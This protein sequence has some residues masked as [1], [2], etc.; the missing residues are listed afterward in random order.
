VTTRP[1]SVFR[2]IA[3]LWGATAVLAVPLGAAPG[4]QVSGLRNVLAAENGGQV[5]RFA[6]QADATQWAAAN[7]IDGKHW[8]PNQPQVANQ[9]R[10]WSSRKN[11]FPQELTFGFANGESRTINKIVIDP[12]TADPFFL[13]RGVKD[14]E[15]S[16]SGT[17]LDGVY[18]RV[19]GFRV[20]NIPEAQEFYLLPTTAKFLRVS[21]TSNWGSN[22]FV[23]LGEV[24][25]YEP[26]TPE[27]GDLEE[28]IVRQE[29]SLD[30]LKRYRRA[31]EALK[32]E[33]A[34]TDEEYNL[35]AAVNG[36]GIQ[37][38]TSQYDDS[39]W[40]AR[41][42]IDGLHVVD[43]NQPKDRPRGWSSSKPPSKSAPQEVVFHFANQQARLID[44][45]RLDPR[46]TDPPLIGRHVK[47]FSV[48]VMGPEANAKWERVGSY[49]LFVDTRQTQP[50]FEQ[51][52]RFDPVEAK[53]VKLQV[54]ANYGSDSCCELGEFEVFAARITGTDLDGVIGQLE[55]QLRDLK[56][57]REKQHAPTVAR[58]DLSY[59]LSLLYGLQDLR[60]ALAASLRD[61]GGCPAELA[62]LARPKD[63]PPAK[64]IGVGGQEVTSDPAKWRGPYLAG[65][66][67]VNPFTGTSDASAWAYD[68]RAGE[69]RAANDGTSSRG[70]PYGK[71]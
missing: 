14:V 54:T 53:L 29:Q 60:R 65:G 18:H 21:L 31:L 43:P 25:A 24:E 30:E 61:T 59:E 63:Q 15:V 46:T 66:V 41:N 50:P 49:E 38:S 39:L 55:Q 2:L 52:F 36:G 37:S 42:L 40:A 51:T 34:E 4:A 9:P 13:G 5:L 11:T 47:A 44:R 56:A 23:E 7:V 3:T 33:D 28:I 20:R 17:T 19:A 71:L 12:V 69:V 10:G 62:D 16:V 35:V 22:K 57:L 8:S 45:V 27:M 68:P 1:R 32:P 67:P 26:I 6:S 48:E 70:V 58:P 64:L